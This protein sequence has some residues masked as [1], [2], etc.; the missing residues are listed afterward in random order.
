MVKV[1]VAAFI[2]GVKVDPPN[3][4]HNPMIMSCR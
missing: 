3:K 4:T 2:N 1:Y